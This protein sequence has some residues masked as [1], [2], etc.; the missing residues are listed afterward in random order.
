MGRALDARAGAKA[1]LAA[2]MHIVPPT[3]DVIDETDDPRLHGLASI[4]DDAEPLRHRS[5]PG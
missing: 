1:A 2:S 3:L 5:K 4:A